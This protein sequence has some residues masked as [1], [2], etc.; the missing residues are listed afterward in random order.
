VL[1]HATLLPLVSLN[2]CIKIVFFKTE[3][4]HR[5][6]PATYRPRK[7]AAVSRHHRAML[8]FD[9][10]K[11]SIGVCLVHVKIKSLVEIETM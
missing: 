5:G 2:T 11:G 8:V 10:R 4:V 7:P 9:R 1:C 6:V 3:E